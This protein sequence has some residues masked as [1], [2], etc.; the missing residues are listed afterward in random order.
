MLKSPFAGQF[1]VWFRN[2]RIHIIFWHLCMKEWYNKDK[3][4]CKKCYQIRKYRPHSNNLDSIRDKWIAFLAHSDH[5]I[6]YFPF[7]QKKKKFSTFGAFS[8]S[9]IF[10]EHFFPPVKQKPLAGA[11]SNL[12]AKATHPGI[13]SIYFSSARKVIQQ[14]WNFLTNKYFTNV[15][16][17]AEKFCFLPWN[18]VRL[19]YC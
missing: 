14:C 2:R 8:K 12:I 17:A 3:L 15:G 18:T 6:F 10:S 7:Y 11:Y 13:L 4:N 9:F 1:V 19:H 16:S 5:I